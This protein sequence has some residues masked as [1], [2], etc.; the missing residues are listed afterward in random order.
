MHVKAGDKRRATKAIKAAW[1]KIQHPD[2]AAAFAAIEPEETPAARI[3]RFQP[4]LKLDANA[5]EAKMLDA[6]LNLAAEDFPAAR[7]ALGDLAETHP[8]ARA[9]SLMAAIERGEGASEAVVRGWLAKALSASRG[10]QWVCENCGTVHSAWVPVCTSC[11]AFDLPVLDRTAPG[12]GGGHPKRGKRDAAPSGRGARAR[13]LADG[14]QRPLEADGP[15]RR[16]V[17]RAR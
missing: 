13:A 11:E 15:H 8:T 16:I 14:G 3:K 10:P 4:L 6:E 1:Q 5:P 7:R 12:R 2:L 9:L 17:R